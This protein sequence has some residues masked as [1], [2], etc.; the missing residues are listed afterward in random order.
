LSGSGGKRDWEM[1]ATK[2]RVSFWSDENVLEITV[3]MVAHLCKYTKT[4]DLHTL[5]GSIL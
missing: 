3:V 1:T 5:K 2:Y 4:T